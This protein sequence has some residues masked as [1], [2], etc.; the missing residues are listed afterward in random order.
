MIQ[1]AAVYFLINGFLWSFPTQKVKVTHGFIFIL[2]YFFRAFI[3]SLSTH[4]L[5]T[6][7]LIVYDVLNVV[8]SDGGHFMGTSL[9]GIWPQASQVFG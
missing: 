8:I 1:F 5:R 9:S 3:I 2:F 6:T 7:G 4:V